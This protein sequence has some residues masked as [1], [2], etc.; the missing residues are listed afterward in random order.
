MNPALPICLAVSAAAA[1]AVSPIPERLALVP[2]EILTGFDE[3]GRRLAVG[4]R[5]RQRDGRPLHRRVRHRRGP[6]RLRGL[7][8]HQ[9]RRDSARSA[10]GAWTS[11]SAAPTACSTAS[12]ATAARTSPPSA[13][14]PVPD[15]S[16]SPTGQSSRPPA[17]GRPSASRSSGY[18]PTFFGEDITGRAPELK[19]E[20]VNGAAFYIYDKKDGPFRLEIEWIG[21]YTD[22][23]QDLAVRAGDPAGTPELSP[24]VA[25]HAAPRDRP[26]A[27]RPGPRP[28][29]SRRPSVPTPGRPA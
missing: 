4:H 27:S 29:T 9:R 1:F 28:P 21:T 3:P 24:S 20:D 5:E 26:R 13:T 23:A 8:Q 15:R 6:P 19:A 25:A 16:T 17:T 10:H 12:R 18:N 22:T 14:A 11:T 7:H 2:D